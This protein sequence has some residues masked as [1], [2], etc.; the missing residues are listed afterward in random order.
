MKTLSVILTLF[1]FSL[2]AG[3]FGTEPQSDSISVV[4][5][6]Q[7]DLYILKIDKDLVGAKVIV[8]CS[9]GEEVSKL[10]IKRKRIVID[11]DEVKFGKYTISIVKDG[12][13]V[14]E[15]N[16]HKQLILSQVIR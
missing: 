5:S 9:N 1:F 12:V 6:V 8:T 3:A 7:D 13:T 2:T 15:F 10:T 4:E 16:Y 14:E 11:F